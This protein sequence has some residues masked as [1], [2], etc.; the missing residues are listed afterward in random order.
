[1]KNQES[2]QKSPH[3]KS[4]TALLLVDPLNDL[5]SEGGMAWPMGEG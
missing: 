2:D 1:M 5:I 4:E 3:P